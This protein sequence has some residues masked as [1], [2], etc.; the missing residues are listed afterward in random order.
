MPSQ[1][2]EFIE[3]EIYRHAV[4][5]GPLFLKYVLGIYHILRYFHQCFYAIFTKT[6]QWSSTESEKAIEKGKIMKGDRQ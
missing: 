5:T 6:K 3:K 2:Q 1:E 4:F